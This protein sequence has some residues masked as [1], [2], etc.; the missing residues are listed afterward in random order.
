MPPA[1]DL[2]THRAHAGPVE[3]APHSGF[4]AAVLLQHTPAG[5]PP[6]LDLMI[7]PPG[8]WGSS[9]MNRDAKTLLTWRLDEAPP[10]HQPG[11]RFHATRLPEHRQH[12]LDFE[13]PLTRGRGS[14]RRLLAGRAAVSADRAAKDGR[15]HI[16]LELPRGRTLLTARRVGDALDPADDSTPPRGR[17]RFAVVT[18]E[19]H[20]AAATRSLACAD[21]PNA[22]SNPPP[23]ALS[24]CMHST[25]AP[26]P[27]TPPR[28][29][30][31]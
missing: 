30:D 31:A 23:G 13:G 24:C 9:D 19:T 18:A 27:T 2:A 15:L 10:V 25:P 17:W 22:A 7:A 21:C 11:A 5:R 3:A 28:S 12:Y 20:E 6:H 4:G 26:T 14:I 1:A 16:I 8:V 29:G